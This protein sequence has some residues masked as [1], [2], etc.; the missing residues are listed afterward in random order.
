MYVE[1]AAQPLLA[2]HNA[3]RDLTPL[4]YRRLWV[5]FVEVSELEG[6]AVVLFK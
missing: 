4:M 2:R 1:N 6:G 3:A 5:A